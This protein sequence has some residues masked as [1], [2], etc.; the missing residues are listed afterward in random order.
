M[1][2]FESTTVGSCSSFGGAEL[3]KL[4]LAKVLEPVVLAGRGY[5][6]EGVAHALQDSLGL[7]HMEWA[8]LRA[9][10]SAG[11]IWGGCCVIG[12]RALSSRLDDTRLGLRALGDGHVALALVLGLV[13]VAGRAFLQRYPASTVD[14]HSGAVGSSW[15]RRTSLKSRAHAAAALATPNPR[16]HG[17]RCS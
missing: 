2:V 7:Q 17:W 15:A 14:L 6:R 8:G 11:R 3:A 1:F 12:R 4:A 13:L 9:R 16:R 5:E 10:G